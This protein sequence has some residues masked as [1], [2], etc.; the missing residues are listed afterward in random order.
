MAARIPQEFIDRLLSRVDVVEVIS[1]RVPLRK[2]GREF[3]AC[4]PFHAERTPSFTVSP[5]KQFYHCFGC[6]AHGTAVGFLMEYERLGFLDAVAELARLAGLELPT[7]TA[8]GQ[9]EHG[10]ALALVARAED[11]YRR[12]LREH[13]E[14]HKAIDYLRR[15]RGLN[16]EVVGAF[17]IGYAPPGWDNLV[18]FLAAEGARPAEL[19]AAGL[20]S[21]SERGGAYDRFRDRIVFPIRDR[22]GRTVAFGARAL[23]DATPK[24]LNSPETP[25]F[26]K[27]RELYGLYEART[28]QRQLKRLLVVEGYMDVVALAQHGIGYA[29]ATLGTAT[30]AEHLERLFRITGEVVFCFDGDAAGRNA[31]WR[32]LENALPLLRDGRQAGFLFLPEGEDP[33]SLVRKEGRSAFEQRLGTTLSL[34]DF[35]FRHLNEGAVRYSLDERSRLVER[36]CGLLDKLPDGVFRDLLVQRLAQEAKVLDVR[37][38]HRLQPHVAAPAARPKADLTRTPLRR[39]IAALLACPELAHK[40]GDPQRFAGIGEPGLELWIR[41]VELLRTRTHIKTAAQL[42]EQQ[43]WE[44]Q[45]RRILERLAQWQPEPGIDVEAEFTGALQ[46]LEE[47]Y[48]QRGLY[49]KLARGEL[50]PQERERLRTRP[51]VE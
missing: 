28:S 8:A 21:Q 38:G 7:G 16:G 45:T 30:T 19:I 9:D 32:A 37:I 43:D 20:A 18:R 2:A 50:T 1:A 33:D 12:Q 3:A 39:A 26:H 36:A 15:E 29:V 25:F 44:A 47:I 49:D 23:G 13:P 14:R 17:G 10:D 5:A 46:R 51:R 48:L 42:L 24:Y 4:C 27:G 11:F 6:G 22:R 34:S 41:I 40:A 31:A 35:F